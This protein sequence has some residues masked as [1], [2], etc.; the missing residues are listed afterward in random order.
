MNYQKGNYVAPKILVQYFEDYCI[1]SASGY[2]V[3]EEDCFDG[4]PF[5]E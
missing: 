2:D 3:K 4:N 1:C 5:E